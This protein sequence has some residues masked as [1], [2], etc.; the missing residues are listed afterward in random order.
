MRFESLLP[1]R[2]VCLLVCLSHCLPCCSSHMGPSLTI[3]AESHCLYA[4]LFNCELRVL[5]IGCSLSVLL[6]VCLSHCLSL[7]LSLC[8]FVCLPC[9][10]LPAFSSLC[11]SA[12][13]PALLWLLLHE[14]CPWRHMQHAS[15]LQL[16]L[17]IGARF[18][19][20]NSYAYATPPFPSLPPSPFLPTAQFLLP[21]T[22]NARIIMRH[23]QPGSG[24]AK[25]VLCPLCKQPATLPPLLVSPFA[26]CC[27]LAALHF[28]IR[29]INAIYVA[30]LPACNAPWRRRH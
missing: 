3:L 27:N 19:C 11:L 18:V 9:L 17:R 14:L 29:V 22:H 15:A 7:C 10:A 5:C 20:A 2:A 8:L 1:V 6:S 25:P 28:V 4:A 13:A 30:C 26:L 21:A 16:K 24:Q 12:T 23:S